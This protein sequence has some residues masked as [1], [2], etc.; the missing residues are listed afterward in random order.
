MERETIVKVPR[1][2]LDDI[3]NDPRFPRGYYAKAVLYGQQSLSGADVVGGA[4]RWGS[5][6]AGIRAQV[7]Q[8]AAKYGVRVAYSY[9]NGRK[10][11]TYK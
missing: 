4:A 11:W 2:V 9:P 1:E 10:V 3:Y 5:W 7:I 8:I 6:Y